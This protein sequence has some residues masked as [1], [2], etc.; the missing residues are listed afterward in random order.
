[1]VSIARAVCEPDIGAFCGMGPLLSKTAELTDGILYQEVKI[2]T[3]RFKNNG[4]NS[5]A[6][7]FKT[8]LAYETKSHQNKSL[9]SFKFLTKF[10]RSI[11]VSDHPVAACMTVMH[12]RYV[13]RIT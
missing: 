4:D 8:T 12:K 2:E 10:T 3:I 7:N 6:S 1:M 9:E 13:I 5:T 11:P